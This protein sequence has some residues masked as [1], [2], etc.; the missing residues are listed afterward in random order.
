MLGTGS[1][2][3]AKRILVVEDDYMMADDLAADLISLGL[4]VVGPAPSIETAMQ[5]LQDS[6][7]IDGAILDINLNGAMVFPLADELDRLSLPFFFGTG[8]DL[9]IVP[10]RHALKQFIRKP[11]DMREIVSALRSILPLDAG[12]QVV[13]R[14]N[15]VLAMLPGGELKALL[16]ALSVIEVPQ[17]EEIQR[18]HHE[19]EQV[20][21]PTACVASIIAISPK[22]QRIEA[23]LVGLD[24]L[25]AF[26]LVAGDRRSPYQVIIQVGGEALRMSATDFVK[27]LEQLPTLRSLAI[28]FLRTLSIQAGY[29][30]LANGR[31]GV[32]QRLARW[33]LM[34]HD[35]T[36]G[37]TIVI[38]HEY[39]AIMLGVRRPG[40][41]DALHLLEGERFIRSLRGRITIR[42]RTA[43]L[44]FA[45]DA[46]GVPETEYHRLMG[47]PQRAEVGRASAQPDI[48]H[49][50]P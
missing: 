12:G 47:P 18:Q 19:V 49:I 23:G 15:N 24:G 34:L 32:P 6:E 31:Y 14:K 48:E 41:T 42:N 13:A 46:Y 3:K 43:L 4:E 5:L 20:Y 17:G 39:L 11:F 28:R 8:Y 1:T 35:R 45:D 26:G 37:D 10:A 36:D 22:G 38:T 16:P 9:D 25:T 50:L 44:G 30:A 40:V 7:K 33:L 21:F 2:S 27:A 29:T